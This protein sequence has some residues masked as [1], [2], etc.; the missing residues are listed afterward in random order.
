M[1]A[2]TK[3]ALYGPT[4][5]PSPEGEGSPDAHV[6]GPAPTPGERGGESRDTFGVFVR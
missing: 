4:P 2:L 6:G 1:P 3:D 5:T